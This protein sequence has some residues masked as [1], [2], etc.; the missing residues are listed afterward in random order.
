MDDTIYVNLVF[1]EDNFNDI[2]SKVKRLCSDISLQFGTDSVQYAEIVDVNNALY[3]A[4][5]KIN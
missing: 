5:Y 1:T 3:D 2:M 4:S